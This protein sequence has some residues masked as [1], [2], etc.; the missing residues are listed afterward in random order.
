MI[1]VARDEFARDNVPKNWRDSALCA[2]T[3]PEAFFPDKGTSP[4]PAKQVCGRCPVRSECL[5]DALLRRERFGVWGGLTERE[6]RVLL[7]RL[8]DRQNL[9]SIEWQDVVTRAADQVMRDY[10]PLEAGRGEIRAA[11]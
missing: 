1:P 7:R 6:R 11:A 10:L 5:D 2:Q 9:G 3:D 4:K 8:P